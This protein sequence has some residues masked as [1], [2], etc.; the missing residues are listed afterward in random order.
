MI[1]KPN[2]Y[3]QGLFWKY[4]LKGVGPT[5]HCA[6]ISDVPN[7][8][9]TMALNTSNNKRLNC[10]SS[11]KGFK[12]QKVQSMKTKMI[13]KGQPGNHG[14]APRSVLGQENEKQSF[15]LENPEPPRIT[16]HYSFHLQDSNN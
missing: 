8:K 3:E 10:L 6:L 5:T 13:R 11:S 12:R 15:D 4:Q 2:N 1:P 16:M 9:M 14:S 7:T